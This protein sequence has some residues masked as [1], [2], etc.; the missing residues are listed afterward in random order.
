M[1]FWPEIRPDFDTFLSHPMKSQWEQYAVLARTAMP[2]EISHAA[3][4]VEWAYANVN[5]ALQIADIFGLQMGN[6]TRTLV[7]GPGYGTELRIILDHGIPATG[8]D[9]DEAAV[10][11][12]ICLGIVPKERYLCS[13]AQEYLSST[14]PGSLDFIVGLNLAPSFSNQTQVVYEL[15]YRVLSQNGVLLL[16]GDGVYQPNQEIPG[17]TV[18]ALNPNHQ[19]AFAGK[20]R[21]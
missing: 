4:W 3:G 2:K 14:E 15:A 16:M 8:V 13:T 17:L 1:S 7:I 21:Y 10:S 9:P 5:V 12:A 6:E 19:F 20:K 18:Y 11:A